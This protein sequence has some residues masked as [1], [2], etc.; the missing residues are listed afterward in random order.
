[1]ITI[2]D[3]TIIREFFIRNPDISLLIPGDLS[4]LLS[5]PY[6]SIVTISDDRWGN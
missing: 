6:S 4:R 1:M 5:M 2:P 3:E